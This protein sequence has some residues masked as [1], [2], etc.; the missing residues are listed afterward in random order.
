MEKER[1]EK[2]VNKHRNEKSAILAILHEVQAEDNQLNAE[3]LKYIALL[4]G[5]PYANVF[6][7][8]TFY[9]A[10]NTEKRGK[11]L[12]RA[13]DGI[14][15]HI[16]GAEEVIKVL[17]SKL[18]IE[19]GETTWDESFGLEKVRCLGLCSISPNVSF[20]DKTYSNLNKEKILEILQKV[21][22][23]SK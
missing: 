3:S 13:C 18:N 19:L 15:C 6:G 21:T 4:L 17:K 14:S 23:D 1:I 11:T 12:V 10:F 5:V 20:N 9:S 22:G 2:I 8:A 16:N 7:L